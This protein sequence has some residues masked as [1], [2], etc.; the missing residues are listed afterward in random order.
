[1]G[2][3]P[4]F[5]GLRGAIEVAVGGGWVFR[6]FIVSWVDYRDV[7]NESSFCLGPCEVG[8]YLALGG[9]FPDDSVD[10]DRARL[11][12]LRGLGR[13]GGVVESGWPRS[14]GS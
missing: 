8:T 1:M 3:F 6:V 10:S 12:V 14:G 5:F 7:C 9:G 2:P 11:G 4:G 13:R